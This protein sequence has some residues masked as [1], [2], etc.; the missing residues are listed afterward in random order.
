MTAPD[1][2]LRVALI[3]HDNPRQYTRMAGYWSYDVPEFEV[4]H[5]GVGGSAESYRRSEFR[6]FDLILWEDHRTKGTW[7]HDADVPLVY[8]VVDSTLS[9]G[10]LE[11]RR[12][13]AAMADLTLVDHDRLER[14]GRRARRWGYCVNDR[15]FRDYGMQK[16]VDVAYHCRVK[17][18]VERE[19]LRGWLGEF[20]RGR[21]YIYAT[22]DRAWEE[23]AR[24]FNRA[25]VS[26]NLARTV[27]N[28]PHRVLDAMA[29]RTCL[30]TSPLPPVSGEERAAG[31]HYVEW[32]ERGDLAGQLEWLLDSGEW[33]AVADAGFELV[34]RVHTWAVRARELRG[35]LR[36]EFG[37]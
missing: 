31:L 14:L 37:L 4:E 10:H 29:C 34:H 20:C 17:G 8:H 11:D 19:E 26:V 25:R 6:G 13:H 18:S 30:L 27:T 3:H 32:R 9:A 24:A 12:R 23:Y 28:R 21:G 36:E 2:A 22:G 33:Q 7:V 1:G 5:F 16:D 15:L 35:I